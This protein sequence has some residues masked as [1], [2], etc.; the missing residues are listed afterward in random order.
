MFF[1]DF[2]IARLQLITEYRYRDYVYDKDVL[3]MIVDMRFIH[4]IVVHFDCIL[5][6]SV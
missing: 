6:I 5:S 4:K 2:L 3:A 1:L